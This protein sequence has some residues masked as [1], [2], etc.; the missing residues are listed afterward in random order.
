MERPLLLAGAFDIKTILLLLWSGQFRA[1]PFSLGE[2]GHKGN[3]PHYT[4]R[5]IA[6]AHAQ[7]VFI[8]ENL[9]V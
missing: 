1:V 6:L 8:G 5:R 2:N 9:F 7:P 3:A 4:H